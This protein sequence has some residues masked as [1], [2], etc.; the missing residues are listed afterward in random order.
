M[1]RGFGTFSPNCTICSFS[2]VPYNL[3]S[4]SVD[5]IF[6]SVTIGRHKQISYL[7]NLTK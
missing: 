7:Q 1:I 2:R 6:L 4:K 5:L 3:A